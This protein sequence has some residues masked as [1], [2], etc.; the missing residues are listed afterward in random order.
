M[1]REAS[2]FSAV[3]RRKATYQNVQTSG[4]MHWQFSNLSNQKFDANFGLGRPSRAPAG[5][6]VWNK[7]SRT[8]YSS[9]GANR[10]NR[11]LNRAGRTAAPYGREGPKTDANPM[12]AYCFSSLKK[13]KKK[14]AS[15]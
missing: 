10:A 6:Q 11:R 12:V 1:P 8:F 4:A 14:K 5:F 7:S 9:N 13:K 15:Q 3:Q 2:K